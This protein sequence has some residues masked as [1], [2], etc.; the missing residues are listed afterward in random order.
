M[1]TFGIVSDVVAMRDKTPHIKLPAAYM[2]N[3]SQRC[4]YDMNGVERMPGR[5]PELAGVVTPDGFPV[6]RYHFHTDEDSNKYAFVLTKSHIYLWDSINEELDL[7]FTTS[8]VCEYWSTVSINGKVIATNF[9]D[10]IQVWS[11]TTP[12]TLFTELGNANGLDIGDAV[13]ITKAKFVKVYETY[14]HFLYV[15]EG[16][17][18]YPARDV[19]SSRGVE[20]DYDRTGGGDTSFRDFKAGLTITGAITYSAS[21]TNLF[22]VFTNKTIEKEWLVEDDAVFDWDTHMDEL[23]CPAPDSIINDN[24]GNVWFLGTDQVIHALFSDLMYS[25]DIEQ[26]I[27]AIH[28]TLNY[29]IRAYYLEKIHRIWWAIPKDGESTQNDRV[30]SLNTKLNAWD[31]FIPIGISAFGE[32]SQQKL[33]TIDTIPF[34]TIDSIGWETIDGLENVVGTT[35]DICGSYDG[36]TYKTL[37]NKILDAGAAFTSEVVLGTDLT[38]SKELDHYKR[39]DGFD[40]WFKRFPGQDYEADIAIQTNDDDDY[41]SV[42]TVD[43]TSGKGDIAHQWCPCDVRGRDFLIKISTDN[44]FIFYAMKFRFSWD[45]EE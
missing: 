13:Y 31:S 30:I 39:I 7:M 43:F 18:T 15:E 3:D 12:A 22:I 16:G 45:G 28:P 29:H 4:M 40:V 11:D 37:G 2:T 36:F 26:T 6:L 25:L 20:T 34:D 24:K 35:I 8:G 42:A 19:W 41:V 27:Q 21:V 5:S 17:T 14:V 23:G 10:K 38:K 32:Y 9:V 33:Y 44:D 1:P